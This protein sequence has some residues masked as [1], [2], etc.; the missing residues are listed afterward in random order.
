MCAY[1]DE[2][3]LH[4]RLP[5]PHGLEPCCRIRSGT[6]AS[7]WLPINVLIILVAVHIVSLTP[8]TGSTRLATRRG[9]SDDNDDDIVPQEYVRDLLKE[10]VVTD[11]C[12]SG[13]GGNQHV[14]EVRT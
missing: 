12:R 13:P 5:G 11:V 7:L 9:G 3:L 1:M 8:R 2:C 10:P 14:V 6:T 4:A